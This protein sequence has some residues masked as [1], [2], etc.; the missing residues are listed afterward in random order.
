MLNVS[1]KNE[2]NPNYNTG[3]DSSSLNTPIS[4]TDNT[5]V[6]WDGTNG[7]SIQ[8]STCTIDDTGN[9]GANQVTAVEMRSGTYNDAIGNSGIFDCWF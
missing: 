3:S 8:N 9:V 7:G 2:I 6:R 5:I 4:T 1:S